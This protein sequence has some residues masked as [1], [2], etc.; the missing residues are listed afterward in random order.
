MRFEVKIKGVAECRGCYIAELENNRVAYLYK[1]TG[2]L[3][4]ETKDRQE[5][6]RYIRSQ[7]MPVHEAMP[8]KNMFVGKIAEMCSYCFKK[9]E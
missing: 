5:D 7:F 1:D 2:M 3:Q 4:I 9:V 8:I 6:I